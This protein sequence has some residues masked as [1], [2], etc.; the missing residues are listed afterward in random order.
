MLGHRGAM[1]ASLA[2]ADCKVPGDRCIGRVG[3]GVDAVAASALDFGRYTVAWGCVGIGQACLDI[4]LQ[5]TAIRRQFGKALAEH[6]LIRALL[7]DL[8]AGVRYSGLLCMHAG[9]LRDLG[10]SDA[11]RETCLAKYVSAR[12]CAE[13]ASN[14]VQIHGAAGCIS[15]HA[16]QRHYRDAKIMEIIEGSTQIQQDLIARLAYDTFN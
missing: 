2:F 8:L 3:F 16:A 13:A 10:E 15:A 9:R 14:A 1:L 12:M 6:Q 5:H 11:L 7:T 4:C